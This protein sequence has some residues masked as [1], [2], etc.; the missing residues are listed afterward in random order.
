MNAPNRRRGE[1]EESATDRGLPFEMGS[2]VPA[3]GDDRAGNT[4]PSRPSAEDNSGSSVADWTG[5]LG[6]GLLGDGCGSSGCVFECPVVECFPARAASKA[7][8]ISR[9]VA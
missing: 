7:S 8:S 1:D 5:G 2:N 4:M 6:R 3:F 9:D